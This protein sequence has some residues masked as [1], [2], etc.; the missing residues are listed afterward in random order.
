M[1]D[2]LDEDLIAPSLDSISYALA[3]LSNTPKGQNL[4]DS[5][6]SPPPLQIP[7]SSPPPVTPHYP[8]ASSVQQV[9]LSNVEAAQPGAASGTSSGAPTSSSSSPLTS[10]TA[11]VQAAGLPLV[12]RA[13]GPYG[14]VKASGTVGQNQTQRLVTMASANHRPSSVISS[15]G[16]AT[17]PHPSPSPPKQRTLPTASP[18]VSPHQKGFGSPVGLLGCVGLHQGLSK[19]G[20]KGSSTTPASSP[21]PQSRSNSSTHPSLHSFC[22]PSP[23]TSSPSPAS[24]TSHPP[25]SKSH[26]HHHH[27][28]S[29]FI[30]PMQATLTKSPHSKSSSPIIKLTPRPPAPNPPPSTSP[31]S[32]SSPSS[33]MLATQQHQYSSKPFRSPYGAPPSA[34]LK[35]TAGSCSFAGAQKPQTTTSSSSAGN[36]S[37]NSKGALSPIYSPSLSSSG[38]SA[39]AGHGQRQRVGGGSKAANEWTASGTLTT[40]STTS[41]LSQVRRQNPPGGVLLASPT[42]VTLFFFFRCHRQARLFW[43]PPQ[44]SP[45]ALACWGA[46]CPSHYPS[47]SPLC[48]TSAPLEPRGPLVWDQHLTPTQDTR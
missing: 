1:S 47:S 37:S 40:S 29:N 14:P 28:Q 24:Q 45:W 25:Q 35:P 2:S 18:L 17:Q 32:S 8:S 6:L 39:P 34:Q 3:P 12:S 13:N 26:S 27:Q 23:V 16:G 30:T 43:A 46:S 15:A 48:S 33:Q 42:V 11:H 44:P 20:A 19:S 10:S 41:H 31:S 9:S 38:P 36:S 22:P 4:S 5:P 7:T 21:S